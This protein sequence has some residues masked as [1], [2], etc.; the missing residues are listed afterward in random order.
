MCK[1]ASPDGLALSGFKTLST[2]LQTA[3]K[4]LGIFPRTKKVS[5]GHFF[6]LASLGPSSSNPSFSAIEKTAP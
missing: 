2:V 4:V 6:T 5:T 3:S 1:K